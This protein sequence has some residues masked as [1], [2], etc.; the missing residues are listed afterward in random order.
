[1]SYN[2]REIDAPPSEVFAV[3]S[4][5]QTYPEWLLGAANI[6]EVDHNWPSPG[7]KFHHTVGM[8]PLA[9][10][11]VSVVTDVEPDRSLDMNVRARPLV[12]AEVSFRIIGDGDRCM[13]SFEEEPS[14]RLIGNL[15]RPLIDPLTHLRNH[16]SL[17]NLE[18]V[19]LRRRA[20]RTGVGA[21]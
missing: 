6:R 8:R 18:Q 21:G 12:L 3:L 16:H 13:V 1:V 11:D 2:C 20:G 4:D 10:A 14:L 9:L 19:V 5:P 15:V 17:R 7:S